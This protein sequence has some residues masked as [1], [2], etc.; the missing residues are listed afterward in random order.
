MEIGG[1]SIEKFA[2]DDDTDG[3]K[4][5]R[6][7]LPRKP[8]QAVLRSIESTARFE[9]DASASAPG[10]RALETPRSELAAAGRAADSADQRKELKEW[11]DVVLGE[12]FW[13][14][15]DKVN[16]LTWQGGHR[17]APKARQLGRRAE[18]IR[19]ARRPFTKQGIGQ[20]EEEI[21]AFEAAQKPRVIKKQRKEEKDATKTRVWNIEINE[22]IMAKSSGH[23]ILDVVEKYF[24]RFNIVNFVTALQHIARASDSVEVME[25]L[26]FGN[27]VRTVR[28]LCTDGT[29]REDPYSLVSTLWASAKLGPQGVEAIGRVVE[30]V[31][32]QAWKFHDL[33]V[34][35]LSQITWCSGSLKMQCQFLACTT[36]EEDPF[37]ASDAGPQ[38]IG[39]AAQ[40]LG[41]AHA[42]SKFLTTTLVREAM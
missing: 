20:P 29:A 9:A 28:M 40:V 37:R 22:E 17:P 16:M 3:N 14:W 13:D 38:D 8:E 25:D 1:A 12:T 35:E 33:T 30:E 42:L 41:K 6:Q 7:P 24:E 18:Q 26:R 19:P 32:C 27:L 31:L 4:P 39:I 34:Q 36:A 10:S 5:I 15:M 21:E 2:T 11:P 23:Q